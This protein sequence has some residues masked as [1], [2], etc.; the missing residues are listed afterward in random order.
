VPVTLVPLDLTVRCAV[1]SRWL[2]ELAAAGPRGAAL[3]AMAEYN[4]A[5]FRAEAG[6][7]AAPLHDAVAVLEAVRPGTLRTEPMRLAVLRAPHDQRGRLTVTDRAGAG[8]RPVDVAVDA[9][10]PLLHAEILRR[11]RTLDTA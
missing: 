3:S 6:V 7:D 4:R 11:L 2:A 5:R 10:I 9:D 1:P 8:P